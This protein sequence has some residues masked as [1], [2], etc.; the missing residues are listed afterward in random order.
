MKTRRN[1]MRVSFVQTLV[2][3]DEPVLVLLQNRKG[4]KVVAYIVRDEI[5]GFKDPYIAKVASEKWLSAYFDQTIDL[6][7]LMSDP[8]SRPYI[9]DWESFGEEVVMQPAEEVVEDYSKL[10]P[11]PGIFARNHTERRKDIFVTSLIAHAFKIDGRWSAG[12]FSRF[13]RKLADLYALFSFV[14]EIKTSNA[15]AKKLSDNIAK[16]PWQRGG[17]YVGFFKDIA[18]ESREEYPLRVS[19]ITYASPGEIEVR[20]VKSSLDQIDA[21]VNTLDSDKADLKVTYNELKGILERDGVLGTDALDFSARP[22]SASAK[23]R[24]GKLLACMGIAEPETILQ[25]CENHLV[26]YSKIALAI[27]RRGE[28]FHRFHAEGRMRLPSSRVASS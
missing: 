20:G 26:T 11:P 24:A 16:Y 22:V 17:S 6:S 10:L 13:Y 9:F 5:E 23:V 15:L 7:Y 8:K 28:D 1:N 3:F 27:Y 25:A 18:S 14:D 4:T 12:D 21:L 19:R 2:Y